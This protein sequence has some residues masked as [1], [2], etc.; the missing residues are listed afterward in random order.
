MGFLGGSTTRLVGI[1]FSGGSILVLLAMAIK[2]FNIKSVS[3]EKKK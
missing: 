1:G 2:K 3:D